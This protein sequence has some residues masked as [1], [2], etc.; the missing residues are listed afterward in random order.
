[1]NIFNSLRNL[2]VKL[3]ANNFLKS[4]GGEIIDLLIDKESKLITATIAL[5][6]E[7]RPVRVTVSGVNTIT[8]NERSRLS[9]ENIA[10]DREW[11]ATAVDTLLRRYLP[12]N[13]IEIPSK[14]AGMLKLGIF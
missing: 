14:F 13:T 7:V 2:S 8:I 12:D 9:F 11:I 1:M 10:V 3:L 5:K 4:Y 6:G